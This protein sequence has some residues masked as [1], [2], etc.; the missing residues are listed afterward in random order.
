MERIPVKYEDLPDIHKK[1][2]EKYSRREIEGTKEYR[3]VQEA[4]VLQIKYELSHQ[5]WKD[6]KLA[7]KALFT[8][9]QEDIERLEENIKVFDS[10]Q[11]DKSAFQYPSMVKTGQELMREIINRLQAFSDELKDELKQK[12]TPPPSTEPSDQKQ[13]KKLQEKLQKKLDDFFKDVNSDEEFEK[14]MDRLED[15]YTPKYEIYQKCRKDFHGVLDG[16]I[17]GTLS[18]KRAL[19]LLENKYE[20]IKEEVLEIAKRG[21]FIIIDDVPE[22]F[23]KITMTLHKY[24]YGMRSNIEN[25]DWLGTDVEKSE[26]EK[27]LSGSKPTLPPI[28]QATLTEGL[29][30]DAVVNGKHIKREGKK[31]KEIIKWMIDYSGYAD[32]LTSDLYMAY[33]QTDVKPQSIG[34]YISR[35]NGEAK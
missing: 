19:L 2:F 16:F 21:G 10:E 8:E 27:D 12:I 3:I 20:R 22:E 6:G 26:Q 31:D 33:I 24:Y 7:G 14:R 25:D 18:K 32:T 5:K 28:I 29:L 1:L 34:Q 23:M 13:V 30:K 17:A 4:V 35:A 15:M 11:I 9:L